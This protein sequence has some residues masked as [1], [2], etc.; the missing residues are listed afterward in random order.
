MKNAV[1]LFT[2]C[3]CLLSAA[4]PDLEQLLQ[5]PHQQVPQ[6]ITVSGRFSQSSANTPGPIYIVTAEQISALQ[7]RSLGDI[8]RLFPGLH[9]MQDSHFTYLNSRGIGQPGDFNSRLLFLIDGARINENTDG[10]GLLGEEFFLDTKLIDRVEY[11]PGAPS[12]AYGANAMLG[13][14]HVVTKRARDLSGVRA[15]TTVTNHGQQKVQ[16][17]AGTG[18][19][20]NFEG[21]LSASLTD[22]K[23]IPILLED[24]PGLDPSLNKELIR[25]LSGKIQWRNTSLL[26]STANRQRTSPL[27]TENLTLEELISDE[28]NKNYMASL[29]H[30]HYFSPE[31]SGYFTLSSF[32]TKFHRTDPLVLDHNSWTPYTTELSGR[33]TTFDA[34][35]H[36][37]PG[38]TWSWWSGVELIRDHRQVTEFSLPEFEFTERLQ[39]QNFH[40]GWY[41]ELQW[42]LSPTLSGQLGIRYDQDDYD[43]HHYSPQ[44][45]FIWHPT[46]KLQLSLRHG[47]AAR[48]ASFIERIYNDE[49]EVARPE[50]ERIQSTDLLLR[51]RVSDQLHLFSNLYQA[52]LKQLIF[53]PHPLP[54]FVNAM[55]VDSKGAES[56]FEWR[57]AALRW[58][59]SASIQ[60]SS[61]AESARLDNSPTRLLKSQ[62]EWAIHPNWQLHWQVYGVSKRRYDELSLPGYL[63]HQ[64]GLQ[65]QPLP[66]LTVGLTLNNSTKQHAL[67]IPAIFYEAYQQQPRSLALQ[68]QWRLR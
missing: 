54:Y 39:G 35:L 16:L 44:A 2:L 50:P 56:G 17:L 24:D 42:Q 11:H 40:L 32:Q 21:W 37:K 61:Q 10:A 33:W 47:R 15:L 36:W 64:L 68:L 5:Q 1:W 46:P 29:R 48:A 12:A 14:I 57:R 4:V 51:F 18:S 62:L 31:L 13:V 58:Q 60:H 45:A 53:E 28:Y 7:L 43:L 9:V 19:S 27:F 55:P 41:S 8:L 30:D 38:P 67:E 52:R 20:E 23:N 34:R 6:N 25:K 59:L 63:L 66:A 49:L 22:Q 26:L 65:W 3:S